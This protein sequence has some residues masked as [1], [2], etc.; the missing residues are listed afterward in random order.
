MIVALACDHGGFPVKEAVLKQIEALGDEVLDF[1]AFD[2]KPVDY[3]DFASKAA[4]AVQQGKA[5][6]AVVICGS[7]IGACVT[8]NKYKGVRA[9]VA[10]DLYSAKQGVEHDN[11]NVI[12]L[13]GRIVNASQA[14]ALVKAFL[15]A[16]FNA[17]QERY[18]RRLDKVSAIE[19]SNFK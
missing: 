15:T 5:Q 16:S 3:P 11:M 19:D 10:H 2:D 18:G 4:L 9:S 1:G 13:G 8:A 6:R 17:G 12:C 7:G 14:Q